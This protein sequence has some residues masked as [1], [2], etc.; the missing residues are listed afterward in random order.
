LFAVGKMGLHRGRV[1][2][3]LPS[4]RR[5]ARRAGKRHSPETVPRT[6]SH[7]RIFERRGDRDGLRVEGRWAGVFLVVHAR[8]NGKGWGLDQTETSLAASLAGSRAERELDQFVERSVPNA[9]PAPKTSM[10]KNTSRITTSKPS[11]R[12]A[13]KNTAPTGVKPL[14]S[15]GVDTICAKP[16]V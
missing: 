3:R 16:R 14:A 10:A 5:T 4:V 9:S 2:G 15:S 13:Q 8:P 12:S 11:G 6:L 1:R 7:S